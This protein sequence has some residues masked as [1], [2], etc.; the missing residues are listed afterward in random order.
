[1][2]LLLGKMFIGCDV[3]Y[4]CIVDMFVK[5]EKLLVDF[6]NCVIYYVGL[7]DLVCDEV[8]GLVGLMMVMC[9]DKFIEMMFV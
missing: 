9:M 1:M 5:G 6:M 7:V 4:K 2:L 3:V 8:V